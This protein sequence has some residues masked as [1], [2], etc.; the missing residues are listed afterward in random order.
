MKIIHIIYCF[1]KTSFFSGGRRTP[2][3]DSGDMPARIIG[4]VFIT[5][6]PPMCFLNVNTSVVVWMLSFS[7][8]CL[9]SSI[10]ATLHFEAV[11]KFIT[12][13]KWRALVVQAVAAPLQGLALLSVDGNCRP[14]V[15]SLQWIL[16]TVNLND[17]AISPF[18][19]YLFAKKIFFSL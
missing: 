10:R 3:A 9:H 17:G 19:C 12:F 13:A 16:Y 4:R 11:W 2:W 18:P 15:W 14:P 5:V 6:K 8:R 1:V 7:R